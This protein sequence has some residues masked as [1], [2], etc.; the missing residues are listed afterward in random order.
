MGCLAETGKVFSERL[1]CP[2][3]ELTR[4]GGEKIASGTF[5]MFSF[6]LLKGPNSQSRRQTKLALGGTSSGFSL[7]A[8]SAFNRGGRQMSPEQKLETCKFSYSFF[9]RG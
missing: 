7:F 4:Y 8:G 3:A 1:R 9:F 5:P 6:S 2:P